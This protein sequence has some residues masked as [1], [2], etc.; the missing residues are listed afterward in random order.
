MFDWF[1]PRCPVDPM[2]KVWVEGRLAWLS[3]QF[4]DA[5]FVERPMVLR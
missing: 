4:G 3:E 5:L 1:A 2:A